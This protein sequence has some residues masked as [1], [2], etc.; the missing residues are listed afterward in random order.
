MWRNLEIRHLE[1]KNINSNGFES[2]I[3]EVVKKQLLINLYSKI[4][5]LIR[6]FVNSFYTKSHAHRKSI[7]KQCQWLGFSL[8]SLVVGFPVVNASIYQEKSAHMQ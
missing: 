2:N 1:T 7:H 4:T 5:C 6:V 3:S 8:V